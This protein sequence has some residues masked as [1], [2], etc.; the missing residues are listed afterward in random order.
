[1]VPLSPFLPAS[2]TWTDSRSQL[3][4]EG[5]MELKEAAEK[6][7]KMFLRGPSRFPLHGKTFPLPLECG[8]KARAEIKISL[9]LPHNSG[10]YQSPKGTQ[11]DGC[12]R[13]GGVLGEMEKRH[14]GVLTPWPPSQGTSGD[15]TGHSP[16]ATVP[17]E[18]SMKPG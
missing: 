15:R 4:S 2:S 11:V 9:T 18:D 3:S 10:A 1:M 8:G 14:P 7:R 12:G 17:A 6:G 16:P 13:C 5:G